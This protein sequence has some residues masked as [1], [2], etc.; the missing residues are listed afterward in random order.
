MSIW[1]QTSFIFYSPCMHIEHQKNRNAHLWPMQPLRKL[2]S[3]PLVLLPLDGFMAYLSIFQTRIVEEGQW[4]LMAIF[5]FASPQQVSWSQVLLGLYDWNPNER[6][7]LHRSSWSMIK[8]TN[9]WCWHMYV[10]WIQIKSLYECKS[11]TY[12]LLRCCSNCEW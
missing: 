9:L 6:N 12:V 7:L 5:A 4:Y 8:Y 3:L 2:G 10:I 11:F 1:I